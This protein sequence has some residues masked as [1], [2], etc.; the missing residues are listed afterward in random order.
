MVT[1]TAGP[2]PF[3]LADGAWHNHFSDVPSPTMTVRADRLTQRAKTTDYGGPVLSS[4]AARNLGVFVGAM[5][6]L[7]Y[8][9]ER[10]LTDAGV[11]RTAL[12]DP[13]ARIPRSVWGPVFSR[14]LEQRPMKNAGMRVATVTPFGAFPLIDY[15]IATSQNVGEGVTRL[16]R[17]LR[18]AEARS[19]PEAHEEEDPIRVSLE[20]SDTPF[21]AEFTVTLNLLHLREQT[22][23]QARAA[24]ASFCHTPDDVAEMERVLGCP[25][26]P[27]ASWNGWALARETWQLPLRR[28]D[29]V[30]SSLL[31]R[32]ADEAM[33]RLPPMEDV[34]ADVRRAL[35]PRLGGGDTRIETIA[36]ALATSARSLQR[37]LAAAGV[38][39]RQL[40]DLA[41]KEAA[42][43]YLRDSRFSIGEVAYLLGYSEPAAFNRAFRRWRNERPQAFRKRQRRST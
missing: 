8:R 39:Y 3:T 6:R 18:L 12:E 35:A 14:A 40:L 5:E 4:Y 36:R 28:R 27:A 11:H 41:R 33:A 31:Q 30:L 29:R 34:A 19:V 23:N 1:L 24:Y 37:R 43:R 7:G 15:L 10:L 42:E 32:Q 21:S 16:G 38:S 20:G 9:L 26:H 2:Q 22:E 25:V 13:D 17:Y